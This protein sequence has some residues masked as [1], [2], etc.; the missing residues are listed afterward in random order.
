M[1]SN[2][3]QSTIIK[4]QAASNSYRLSDDFPPQSAN[5]LDSWGRTIIAITKDNARHAENHRYLWP[6]RQM[7]GNVPQ[8][9]AAPN[10]GIPTNYADLR[11]LLNTQ[12]AFAARVRPEQLKDYGL[13]E[14]DVTAMQSATTFSETVATAMGSDDKLTESAKQCVK[15]ANAFIRFISGGEFSDFDEYSKKENVANLVKL[16]A[17]IRLNIDQY[18]IQSVSDRANAGML[19]NWTAV[20]N[21]HKNHFNINEKKFSYTEFFRRL[22]KARNDKVKMGE[23]MAN[24]RILLEE[25]RIKEKP[26]E[27]GKPWPSYRDWEEDHAAITQ[28]EEYSPIITTLIHYIISEETRRTNHSAWRKFEDELRRSKNGSYT[29]EELHTDRVKLHLLMDQLG[30]NQNRQRQAHT[31]QVSALDEDDDVYGNINAINN[32]NQNKKGR[33]EKKKPQ[34]QRNNTGRKM[35]HWK[36]TDT[37]N[38]RKCYEMFKIKVWHNDPSGKWDRAAHDKYV[39]DRQNQS[40]NRQVIHRSNKPRYGSFQTHAISNPN[41]NPLDLVNQSHGQHL[42]A[43]SIHG[44]FQFVPDNE[45]NH[46]HSGNDA[47][48]GRAAF[49]QQNES[50]QWMDSM[51]HITIGNNGYINAVD[52]VS[53]DAMV[54]EL[55]EYIPAPVPGPSPGIITA[56]SDDSDNMDNESI[57]DILAREDRKLAPIYQRLPPGLVTTPNNS[58]SNEQ[59][60]KAANTELCQI[61]QQLGD[62][63]QDSTD[64]NARAASLT[65]RNS[66]LANDVINLQSQLLAH[67]NPGELNRYHRGRN[68]RH[69]NEINHL[70][71]EIHRLRHL[72]QV[73]IRRCNNLE[74]VTSWQSQ[75]V[76]SS[77]A[78]TD[79]RIAS[80]KKQS[81]IAI[82][83]LLSKV[84]PALKKQNR[85]PTTQQ[86]LNVAW[87]SGC[88]TETEWT[89][90]SSTAHELADAQ[91]RSDKAEGNINAIHPDPDAFLSKA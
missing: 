84:I 24:I 4:L 82:N 38:C 28:T 34:G 59:A 26:T 45:V 11:W 30:I 86:L 52:A 31:N 64:A 33:Q 37:N 44:D 70:H 49:F 46:V 47:A 69:T 6:T 9:N 57:S 60:L 71:D 81:Q 67:G 39:Q 40:N 88:Y 1:A 48:P 79:Q 27:T 85:T 16:M 75:C 17:Q 3:E 76:Q 87:T 35:A 66:D 14:T 65:K 54:P 63:L 72:L 68:R 18:A 13:T 78:L 77:R 73:R 61:R 19:G 22:D 32:R 20:M 2:I 43:Q 55:P 7:R 50:P 21:A 56:S 23:K 10:E 42:D 51:N 53:T 62:A 74:Q 41:V 12:G 15:R 89:Q 91:D 36:D 83:S 80:T 29:Y 58:M 8:Y 90:F 25:I 5:Q